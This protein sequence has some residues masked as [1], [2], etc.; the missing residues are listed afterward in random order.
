MTFSHI[1]ITDLHDDEGRGEY[2]HDRESDIFF[3]KKYY[4]TAVPKETSDPFTTL[5]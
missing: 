3:Y 5:N 4:S 1:G 2:P